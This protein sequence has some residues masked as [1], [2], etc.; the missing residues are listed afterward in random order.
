VPDY[1]V[2]KKR[3]K[4][5]RGNS[6]SF[7][8]LRKREEDLSF[9]KA[10]EE[11]PKSLKQVKKKEGKRGRTAVL[12]SCKKKESVYSL[13]RREVSEKTGT[14]WEEKEGGKIWEKKKGRMR[15]VLFILA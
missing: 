3:E 14:P 1:G 2:E 9:S 4:K 15:G 5:K 7:T 10:L 13:L 12:F 8:P 6:V 11:F